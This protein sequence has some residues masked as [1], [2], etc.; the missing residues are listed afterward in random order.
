MAAVLSDTGVTLGPA[1]KRRPLC[2]A[3]RKEWTIRRF[4]CTYID[5][6]PGFDF[7]EF[8]RWWV[9]DQYRNPQWDLLATC[10]IDDRPGLLMGE[11]KAH[12][13]ELERAGKLLKDGA[14]DQTKE[15]HRRIGKC[16]AE[17][18]TDLRKRG[19]RGVRI[20]RDTHY[21][22]SNRVASAWRLARCGLPVALLY[23]GFLRDASVGVALRDADHWQRVVGAYFDGVLPL[24][25]PGQVISFDGGGSLRLLVR[26]MLV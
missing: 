9:P 5:G 26:S 4:A 23:L 19:F 20:I 6:Y 22:L 14:S 3:D 2:L 13:G 21:Q 12:A 16:I 8:D 24:E 11:A 1:E 17:A 18:A 10:R 15:N 25:L 7:A